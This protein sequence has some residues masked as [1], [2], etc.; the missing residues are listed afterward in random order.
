MLD[1]GYNAYNLEADFKKYLTAENISADSIK[2]Y[3]S[4]Y[5]HFIG[6][7]SHLLSTQGITEPLLDAFMNSLTTSRIQEYKAHLVGD[8]IPEKTIN[9]RLS[10]VRKFCAFCISQQW[11]KTNPAKAVENKQHTETASSETVGHYL[12]IYAYSL[13]SAKIKKQKIDEMLA[14]VQEFLTVINS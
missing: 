4:D 13:Q 6:W 7:L 10:T 5:R 12:K 14:D 1:H 2:N 9:R 11:L 3:L 8:G